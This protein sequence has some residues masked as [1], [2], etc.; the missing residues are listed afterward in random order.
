MALP[1]RNGLL[2]SASTDSADDAQKALG[3]V[4]VFGGRGIIGPAR[5]RMIGLARLI[6]DT[7]SFMSNTIGQRITMRL[8]GRATGH[9]IGFGS[10]SLSHGASYSASAGGAG[11]RRIYQRVAGRY[12]NISTGGVRT[13]LGG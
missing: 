10:A 11:G 7:S 8:R 3:D 13:V 2:F 1:E 12:A 9:I 6:G 4:S 5:G